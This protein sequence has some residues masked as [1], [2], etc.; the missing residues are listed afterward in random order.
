MMGGDKSILPATV[1]DRPMVSE[2]LFEREWAEA[3]ETWRTSDPVLYAATPAEPVDRPLMA[4]PTHF[5]ALANSITHQQVSMAA[6]RAIGA[7]LLEACGGELSAEAVRSLSDDELRGVGLSRPKVVYVRALAD[8][9]IR[10]ELGGL[11]TEADDAVISQLVTLPG[12]GAWTAGM[13]LLF[14]LNRP[15]VLR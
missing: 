5:A 13:F 3:R 1:G 6:G 7:R 9:A 2:R 11:E 8:S 10:G 14:H 4:M 12:I 15:D